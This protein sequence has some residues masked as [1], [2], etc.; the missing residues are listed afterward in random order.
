M[1]FRKKETVRFCNNCTHWVPKDFSWD[2]ECKLGKHSSSDGKRAACDEYEEKW[3]LLS[4]QYYCRD[5]AR[6]EAAFFGGKCIK[7]YPHPK[8]KNTS[9]CKYFVK[10]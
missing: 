9:S 6:W 3:E 4:A 8:G 2:H 1:F 5:C 10:G 7:E